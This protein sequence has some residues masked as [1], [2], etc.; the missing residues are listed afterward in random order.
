MSHIV[1]VFRW[2]SLP[3]WEE[4]GHCALC[5][6]GGRGGNVTVLQQRLPLEIFGGGYCY[7]RGEAHLS[8]FT[9][10]VV[11]LSLVGCLLVILALFFLFF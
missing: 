10:G 2:G 8:R 6:V 11:L 3:A 9:Q 4:T 7:D 5:I 1:A